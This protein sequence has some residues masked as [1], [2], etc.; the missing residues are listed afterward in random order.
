[1]CQLRK[2]FRSESEH[3]ARSEKFLLGMAFLA[4]VELFVEDAIRENEQNQILGIRC[5]EPNERGTEMEAPARSCPSTRSWPT[6]LSPD[7]THGDYLQRQRH[8]KMSPNYVDGNDTRGEIKP[9]YAFL[10]DDIAEGQLLAMD[11]YINGDSSW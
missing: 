3:G 11:A 7:G 6:A 2:T 5:N 1:M 4:I 9:D 8:H 10:T